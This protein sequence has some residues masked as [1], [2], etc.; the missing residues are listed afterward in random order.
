MLFRS[1]GSPIGILATSFILA[2]VFSA[3]SLLQVTQGVPF[4]AINVLMA[5]ILFVVLIKPRILGRSI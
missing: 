2:V 1:G 4:A 5:L 3:G